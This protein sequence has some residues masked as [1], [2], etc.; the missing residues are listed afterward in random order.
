VKKATIAIA[1]LSAILVGSNAW[2]AY[3]VLDAAVAHDYQGASLE[4]NQQAL[5]QS[6]AIL[7]VAAAKGAARRQVISAAHAA[8]P[9]VEPFE[10]DGYVWV[11]RLGL[12]F[13]EAGQLVEAVPNF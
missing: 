5:G 7:K 1:A 10:K 9:E 11:G 6:L 8:W 13:N 12:R 2:W 3:Q 4:E